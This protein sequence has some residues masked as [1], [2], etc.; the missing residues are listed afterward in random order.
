VPQIHVIDPQ[1]G[2]SRALTRFLT[3]AKNPAWSP[4]GR[5]LSFLS[6]VTEE[7]AADMV[8]GRGLAKE[9]HSPDPDPEPDPRVVDRIL[10]REGTAYRDKRRSHVFSIPLRGRCRPRRITTGD[11]DHGPPLFGPR[12]RYVYTTSNRTGDED[13]DE[14]ANI[15]RFPLAGGKARVMTPALNHCAD[16]H[17]DSEGRHLL[18]YAMP[19]DK[20]YAHNQTARRLPLAGGPEEVLSARLDTDVEGVGCLPSTG[21]VV[22]L[23]CLDG[24]RRLFRLAG[25][26]RRPV[27]MSPSPGWV[28]SFSVARDGDEIAL[29]FQSPLHPPDLFVSL[30]ADGFTR[31]TN[32]NSSLLARR[33]L[34]KPSEIAYRGKG[35][36]AIQGWHMKPSVPVRGKAPLVVQIHGGPHVMW[37][38]SFHFEF[39]LM[40]SQGWG[41]FYANPRGSGGY[42]LSFKG[43]LFRNWA[44][45]DSV[46]VLR[47]MEAVQRLGGTDP[48]KLFITGGSYGGYLTAFILGH[49]KRFRAA[50]AQRG[51]YDMT[52]FYGCSDVQMLMEWE[53]ES[54]P[55]D[56]PDLYRRLSPLT[57]VRRMKTP[58]LILHAECDYRAPICTAEELFVALRKL[59]REVRFVRYPREGHELSRSGEPRHRVDR[60]TRIIGWFSD[61]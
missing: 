52:S 1:G 39:Q 4:D 28:E 33:H 58:L 30:G 53:F 13:Q 22:V 20:F 12:G 50:V 27:P 23:A 14:V 25:P 56:D 26:D 32:L 10:Y 16:L 54:Y 59:G 35:G 47:G 42:G 8:R 46:D 34:S 29:A 37:G 51:V 55:W 45:D 24:D 21:E 38:N 43:K 41:I 11:H 19:G 7:E 3:G 15:V 9:G 18:Y 61:H 44:I 31:K 40:A 49:D 6:R 57:Y 60:L 36:L 48:K 5:T 2:E 17:I